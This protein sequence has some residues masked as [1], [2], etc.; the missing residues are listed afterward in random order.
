MTATAAPAVDRPTRPARWLRLTRPARWLRLA[1]AAT[2]AV[3]AAAYVIVAPPS[4]DLAAHLYRAH[5]F[6]A[7]GFVAWDNFWYGGHD[8][9]GYSVLFPAV[10][11]ALSPQLAAALAAVAAAALFES[12]AVRHFGRRAWM[13][14]VLFGA[15][16]AINLYTGRLA[17]AFGT[18]PALG[19]I[20][21]LDRRRTVPACLLAAV[22]ALCSPVAALFAAIAAGGCA[23]AA[24]AGGCRPRAALPGS[25]VGLAAL[26]PIAALAF[27]FPEGGTEPFGLATLL[28]VLAIA[29]AGLLLLPPAAARLRAGIA[30]YAVA[31]LACYVIPSPV[32]SNVAR[33]ATFLAAPLAAL[34]WWPRRSALLAIVIVPLLYVGWQ[35]PVRDV[36]TTAGD[37]SVSAAYYRPLLAFLDRQPGVF[38]T[39]IP[40]T[41]A[42]WEAYWVARAY[43]LARGWERQLDIKDNPLFYGGRLTSTAYAGWLHRNAIRFVALPDVPLDASAEREASLIRSRP[44]YLRQVMRSRHWRVYAV[45]RPTPLATGAAT[46]TAMTAD[47][48]TLTARATGTA[49]VRVRYSPYWALTRG[50][51]CVAPAGA[52]T[53][54][55]VARP[56]RIRLAIRFSPARIGADS[57]RCAI[58]G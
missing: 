33:L 41:R 47:T 51:G 35:A 37:P 15:A 31:A 3:L 32:G 25:A 8:T 49:L 7:D 6:G 27:A 13:G 29:A 50:T 55:T 40:L 54:I 10:S 5:L 56:G 14:A 22:A 36:M 23:V 46:V 42:H 12:L 1:P 39:E 30:V 2:A 24:L 20:V 17:L 11:A 38:R 43:P 16:T 28:P 26:A 18:L 48:L 53:R 19:A 4:V 21:A 57:R 44:P 58:S 45:V 52:F 9:P 34:I